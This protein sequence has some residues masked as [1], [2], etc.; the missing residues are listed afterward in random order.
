MCVSVSAYVRLRVCACV[1]VRV[2]IRACVYACVCAYV[3]V[4]VRMCAC[5]HINKLNTYTYMASSIVNTVQDAFRI[6]NIT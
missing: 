5:V 1:C 2:S 3:C 6:V 4:C